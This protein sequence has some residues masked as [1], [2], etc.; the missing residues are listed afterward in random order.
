[1][2]RSLLGILTVFL[3]GTLLGTSAIGCGDENGGGGGKV[4]II[5]GEITD[6]TGPASPAI[7]TLHT[8]LEDW[9]RYINEENFIPG[10]ELDIVSWDNKYEVERDIPGYE[11]VK[12]KGAKLIVCVIPQSG[13][14]LKPYADKDET[15]VVNLSVN[16]GMLTPPGWVFGMSA[17]HDPMVKALMKWLHE[18]D[19]DKPGEIPRIGIVG[20]NEAAIITQKKAMEE[21]CQD[22]PDQFTYAGGYITPFN[23]MMFTAEVKALKD[24]DYI[25]PMGFPA[26]TFIKQYQTA[27]YSATYLDVGVATAYRGFFA[28]QCGWPALDGWL[29]ANVTLYRDQDTAMVKQAV[30]VLYRYHPDQAEEI[31]DAGFSYIGGWHNLAATFEILKRAIEQVGPENFSQQAYYDAAINYSTSSSMWEGYPTDY[32]DFNAEKRYLINYIDIYEFDADLQDLVRVNDEWYPL[33][34]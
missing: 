13:V 10:V 19:W 28:R 3:I 34:W 21:Y 11:W 24:C 16:S 32:G 25:L 8:C 6:L 4:K 29:S 14:I 9:V 17:P 22:H 31:I 18:E 7:W 12:Q 5:I 20:W 30:D 1:M 26:C 15:I 27:G 2:R 33:L 23:T